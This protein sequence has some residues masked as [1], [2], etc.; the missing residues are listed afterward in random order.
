[1]QNLLFSLEVVAPV[2]LIIL[3]GFILKYKKMI[4]EQFVSLS[5]AIVFKIALPSLVFSKIANTDFTKAFNPVLISVCVIG[6][7][8][9]F[10][11][12]WL[13]V[14]PITSDGRARGSFI[15]GAYRSNYGVI[16][17]AIILN[18]HGES[19][20]EKAAILLSFIMPLYNVLG[21]IA[22]TIPAR[23]EKAIKKT[24]L[25]FEIFTN[26]LIMAACSGLVVSFFKI[27]IHS[28][29]LS[30]CNYLA[31]LTL[32]LALLG[33]GGSLSGMSVKSRFIESFFSSILKVA[34]FPALFTTIIYFWGFSGEELGIGFVLFAT[35]SAIAGFAM[36]KAMD[37]DSELA[38]N[39]IVISTLMSIVS[40][41]IGIFLLKTFNLI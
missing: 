3:L 16:G 33:I 38:A 9:S 28:I 24:R 7:I 14:I 4:D 37:N 35:P 40:L 18:M 36:A 34:V 15:Q 6:T 25:V 32:P 21:V 39:T 23:K 22:L 27:P 10:L 5:S 17:L 20:L 1:M 8:V 26:P 11:L 30:T 13:I 41:S 2:F 29:I 19:A 12:A 31:A